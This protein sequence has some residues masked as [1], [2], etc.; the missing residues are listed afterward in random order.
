LPQATKAKGNAKAIKGRILREAGRG[1]F[2]SENE[3]G[4][5]CGID[6]D[7]LIFKFGDVV[8]HTFMTV[9]SFISVNPQVSERNG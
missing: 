6:I 2:R 7:L 1:E 3:F 9:Y 8:S 4:K 5:I